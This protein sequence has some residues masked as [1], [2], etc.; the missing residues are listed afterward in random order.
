LSDSQA[1]KAAKGDRGGFGYLGLVL[2]TLL[3]SSP[4][5]G[6]GLAA[7]LDNPV[8]LAEIRQLA[9]HDSHGWIE[10]AF[11]GFPLL[12]LQSPWLFGALGSLARLGVPL[13][14]LYTAVAILALSAPALAFYHL[15]RK[16]AGAPW[17]FVLASTLVVYRW[18]LVGSAATLSGM[19][20]FHLAAGAWLLV[21][22]GLCRSDRTLRDV[23]VLAGLAAFIGLTHMYVTIALVYLA[24]VHG[25]ACLLRGRQG[26]ALLRYDVPALGLGGLSAAA[27]WMSNALAGT[28]ASATPEPFLRVLSRL[29]T[30]NAPMPPPGARGGLQR[31]AAD[32]VWFLD[33]LPQ[34]A[35]VLLAVI[36]LR[37]WSKLDTAARYGASLAGLFLLFLATQS[38]SKLPL[39]GPQGERLIYI[40]KLGLLLLAVPAKDA[41]PELRLSEKRAWTAAAVVSLVCG[42]LASRVVA[43]E[44]LPPSDPQLQSLQ[45][46]WTWMREHRDDSWGRVY[47]Q[48]TFDLPGTGSLTRSHVLAQTA[49][50]AGVEQIGEWYGNTPYQL[51]WLYHPSLNQGF[52]PSDSTL[53]EHTLAM[54]RK[55]NVTHLLLVRPETAAAFTADGRFT[56][57]MRDGMFTLLALQGAQS[58]WAEVVEGSGTVRL[59][60]RPG[61]LRLEHTGDVT[62]AVIREAH[63]PFWRLSPADSGRLSSSP[64]GLMSVELSRQAG[65]VALD[66][67]PPRLPLLISGAGCACILLLGLGVAVTRY[68]ARRRRRY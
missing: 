56:P 43:R 14:P 5:W 47:V 17:A 16:R 3:V 19:F 50:A 28:R 54:C 15:A 45:R 20:G 38:F 55:A 22:D 7:Y 11:A 37:R 4:G 57:L 36:G 42:L 30:A 35:V 27:Y 31:L 6:G 63:H 24:L 41:L 23:P 62:R 25:A 60:R 10:L 39:L 2:L 9:L 48:G 52:D 61:Q 67:Q 64:D 1:G 21:L 29:V 51:D 34:V 26:F 40:V 13:E 46:V 68:S 32:P 18:S 59:E 49:D 66:Y 12:L 65:A 53:V 58:R 8:H 33:A 44:A